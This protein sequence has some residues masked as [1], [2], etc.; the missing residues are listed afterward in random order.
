MLSTFFWFWKFLGEEDGNLLPLP[1]AS[2]VIACW[3][4][5]DNLSYN[6][7]YF[8]LTNNAVL[9]WIQF[10]KFSFLS[11]HLNQYK[12]CLT[13]FFC[14]DPAFLAIEIFCEYACVVYRSPSGWFCLSITLCRVMLRLRYDDMKISTR[15][16]P[17]VV[18]LQWNFCL[19]L[20]VFPHFFTYHARQEISSR[21]S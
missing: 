4:I 21:V 8:N 1:L 10:V 3:H 9:K 12:S 5:S 16:I 19:I 11:P 2:G 20:A 7:I 14:W 6:L 17:S 13:F 18:K 15:F